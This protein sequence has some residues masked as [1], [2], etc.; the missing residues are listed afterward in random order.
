MS[1]DQREG[2]AANLA[3]TAPI[4]AHTVHPM[5]LCPVYTGSPHIMSVYS[6]PL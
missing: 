2:K 6:S 1:D 5:A 3:V 4:L